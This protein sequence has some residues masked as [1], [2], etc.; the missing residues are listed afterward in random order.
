MGRPRV[1][2]DTYLG[3]GLYASFDGY[4]IRLYTER[5]NGTHE[6]FLDDAT[7]ARFEAFVATLRAKAEAS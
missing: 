6:V 3:D 5:A 1:N 2:P 4:Q 7:L